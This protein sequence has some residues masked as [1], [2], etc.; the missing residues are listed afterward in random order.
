[1]SRL[2]VWRAACGPCEFFV[3]TREMDR[4][5]GLDGVQIVLVVLVSI[6]VA[7]YIYMRFMLRAKRVEELEGVEGFEGGGEESLAILGNEHL[8]DEF[9]SKVYDTLVG[10]TLRTDAETTMTL[11]WAK[12]FRPEVGTIQ[13]LDAGCGTGGAVAAFKK[14][15][16]GKAV[17]LDASTAMIDAA[18]RKYPKGDYRV[19]D[20]EQMGLFAAGEFNLVTL[21]YFTYYELRNPD[22]MFKNAFQWLQP[23][24]CLVIHLANREKFDPILETA[25]PFV[26]FSLQKYT[27][28]R[29]TKSTVAF[30]KFDYTAQFDLEGESAEFKEE[31]KF[32]N[33]KSRRQIHS[34]RMP[35]MESVVSR[36]ESN[37]F[38]YKKFIDMTA[39]GYE[40]QY[41]FCFVR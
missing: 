10:G 23:G 38:T 40:Y 27:K 24:G 21:Y 7:N 3:T 15:G 9:Y 33:G 8:Y 25:S 34:L 4:I 37:G 41:M 19:G 2:D 6:L 14:A 28:D 11:G 12:S 17:G 22:A 13:V 5:N 32:K 20:V 36:A 16:C 26:G 39:I 29:V 30:D 35:R 18:R 31:F 1:M